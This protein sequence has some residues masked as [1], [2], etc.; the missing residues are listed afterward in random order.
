MDIPDIAKYIDHTLLKPTATTDQIKQLCVEAVKYGFYSICVN[1]CHINRCRVQLFDTPVKICSVIGFPLGANRGK[2]N[3][4]G[5]AINNGANEL[6]MVIN[7]GYLLSERFEFIIDEISSITDYAHNH[8]VLVKVIIETG[9]LTDNQ[10]I[11]ACE[12]AVKA[13]ADFVKTCTGFNGGQATVEDIRLIRKVVGNKAKTKASGGIR[14]L[15]TAL[16]MIEAGADRLGTSSG[17][18]IMNQLKE[19]ND[20]QS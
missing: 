15:A 18:A 8:G 11:T 19:Q 17:V 10:K 14:D 5:I 3:E 2:I 20:V 16:A 4:A 9:L 6:D 12:L 1:S 13:G 7:I